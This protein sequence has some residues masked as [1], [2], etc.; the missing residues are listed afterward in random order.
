MGAAWRILATRSPAA[1]DGGKGPRGER[2]SPCGPLVGLQARARRE[3]VAGV[4]DRD[5]DGVELGGR[6]AED[7]DLNSQ[8]VRIEHGGAA[9][10]LHLSDVAEKN[11][12]AALLAEGLSRPCG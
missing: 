2:R 11:R 3:D 6:C 12:Q 1:R 4:V 8:E 5:V 9:E 10:D 7:A